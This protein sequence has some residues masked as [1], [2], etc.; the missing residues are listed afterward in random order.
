MIPR[1]FVLIGIAAHVLAQSVLV[2]ETQQQQNVL[3]LQKPEPNFLPIGHLRRFDFKDSDLLKHVLELAEVL[4]SLIRLIYA[5]LKHDD[6]RTTWM[7]GM[8]H[9][10]MSIYTRHPLLLCFRYLY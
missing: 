4:S 1:L 8:L 10:R 2:D 6:R 7:Y 9:S 5:Y 3:N